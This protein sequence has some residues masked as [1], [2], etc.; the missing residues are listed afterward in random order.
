MPTLIRRGAI[1]SPPS[2]EPGAALRVEPHEDPA[3]VADRLGSAAR[4][5]VHFPKFTDGRGYS[6]ARLLR[7]RFGY[8]GELRAVGD[9]PRDQLHYLARCGFDAFLLRD[10]E[11]AK[12][13]L[14]ALAGFSEAYQSSVDRPL[15]L[16]RRRGASSSA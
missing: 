6:I 9:V 10:G 1:E 15:P 2:P 13:A 4:V 5:E 12:G 16:F 3:A 11:D 8:R 14:A 7:E